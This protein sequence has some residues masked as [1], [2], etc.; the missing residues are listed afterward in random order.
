MMPTEF[1]E[2]V[3]KRLQQLGINC[4]RFHY[5]DWAPAPDGLTN[6][7]RQTL[8][9]DKLAQFDALSAALIRHGVWIDLNLH[10]AR[11]Y[12]GLPPGWNRMGKGLDLIHEPYIQSQM[13][14]ARDLLRHVNPHTGRDYAHE[15]GLAF[16]ELNNENT[17]LRDWTVYAG[18]PETFRAPLRKLW[19]EWLKEKYHSTAGLHQAW[20]GGGLR[21]PEL[22]RNG[23]WQSDLK[24]WTYQRSAGE[25]TFE[26]VASGG[27]A[28]GPCAVWDVTEPGTQNWH[29]QV[30]QANLPVKDGETYTL[31]FQARA[32]RGDDPRLAVTVM[33]QQEPWGTVASGATVKLTG[34]WRRYRIGLAVRNPDGIP[35]RLNLSCD[36]HPGRYELADLALRAGSEAP[37]EAGETLETG[38]VPLVDSTAHAG[39][40]QDYVAFLLDRELDYVTRMRKLLREELG[41][42]QMI[43]CTQVSYGGPCGLIREGTTAELI[44]NHAYPDHPQEVQVDGQAMR[45]V[46]QIALS[47]KGTGSLTRLAQQRVAGKPYTVSEFDLNPPNDHTAEVFPLLALMSAYQGWSGFM[48]YVWYNFGTGPGTY[49]IKS[50]WA[51]V[52]DTA[53]MA[54]VPASALLFRQGL[55]EPARTSRVLQIPRQTAIAA[56]A[57]DAGGWSNLDTS[58]LG[59]GGAD[60]WRGKIG[61]QLVD[62]SGPATAT[63]QFPDAP[64]NRVVSDTG[65][66]TAIRDEGKERLEVNAP[67]FRMVSG[68]VAEQTISLGDLTLTFGPTF[69]GFGQAI[70]VSFDGRPLA[71]SKQVLLTVMNRAQSANMAYTA[72]RALATWGDGPTVAEPVSFTAALPGTGWRVETLDPAGRVKGVAAMEGG[73]LRSGAGDGTV[74]YLLSR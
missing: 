70:A 65:Q 45:A 61:Q 74:W 47:G 38:T 9:P 3:A 40:A 23:G 25:G 56:T 43:V 63:G 10:V 30:Q 19:N 34:E 41:A 36:N 18:L 35:V 55:V 50:H 51:T 52:G 68:I 21:G 8:N 48:E 29:H 59:L 72:D 14:F 1:A 62:G 53:Q 5:Y 2:P 33:M 4:V 60:V 37:L 67:A 39:R 11:T 28:G 26:R 16:I 24:D 57:R 64:A 15:P 73:V 49:R 7:D 69:G 58:Q 44:D 66:I 27:P 20:G 71:Q 54:F 32:S 17:A 22:L 42:R 31:T 13:Q 46:R 12:P 6:A